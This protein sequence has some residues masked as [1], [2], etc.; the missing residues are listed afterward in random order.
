MEKNEA[1]IVYKEKDKLNNITLLYDGK[2]I[3]VNIRRIKLDVK[4]DDLYPEGYDMNQ[5]FVSFK[6]RKL[7]HDIERGS[8]KAIKKLLKQN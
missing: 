4:A 7:E 5:L 6:D 8:K 2:F 1:A 3:E